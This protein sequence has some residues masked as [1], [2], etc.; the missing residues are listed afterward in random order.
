MVIQVTH[1]GRGGEGNVRSPSR[2]KSKEAAEQA[3]EK[4]VIR[5]HRENRDSR[6]VGLPHSSTCGI[7]PFMLLIAGD[8]LL[9]ADLCW[10]RWCG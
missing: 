4:E 9:A 10:A 8:L 5:R 6:P 1:A 3:F 7:C 2:G